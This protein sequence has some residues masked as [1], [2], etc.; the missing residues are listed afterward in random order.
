MPALN[1]KIKQAFSMVVQIVFNLIYL[2]NRDIIIG[3]V[4]RLLE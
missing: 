3:K 1:K 2:R 4:N